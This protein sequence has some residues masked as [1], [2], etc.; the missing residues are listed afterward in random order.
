MNNLLPIIFATSFLACASGGDSSL[1]D[2]GVGGAAPTTT[3]SASNGTSGSGGAS[4]A[5]CTP[6]CATDDDCASSCLSVGSGSN[7][8]DTATGV[9]YTANESS[10]PTGVGGAGGTTTG[11]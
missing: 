9:C 5:Q 3:I 11:T 4:T 2:G 6:S 8:C 10:C 1:F 7:C